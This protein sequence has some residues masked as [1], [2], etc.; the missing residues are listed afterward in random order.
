MIITLLLIAL[1]LSF[2]GHIYSLVTYVTTRSERSLRAFVK[3]TM[4][5]IMIAGACIVLFMSRPDLLFRVDVPKLLWVM[6]GFIM[7]VTL[8]VKIKIFIRIYRKAQ[9]PENYHINFFGKKVLHSSVVSRIELA[10]F[11]G[12]IPFFLMSGAY[13]IA[14][15]VNFFLY[16]HL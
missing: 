11:F 13:F 10:V 3:T 4:S 7:L 12:T 9:D 2:L 5:N 1:F 15:L 6:S 8:W 16:R 14:R